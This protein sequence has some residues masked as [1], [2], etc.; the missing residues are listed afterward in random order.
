MEGRN[1]RGGVGAVGAHWG[2]DEDEGWPPERSKVRPYG[3]SRGAAS[4]RSAHLHRAN[5]AGLPNGPGGWSG[6]TH[7]VR[8]HRPLLHR[9]LHP[10]PILISRYRKIIY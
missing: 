9:N 5:T 1:R 8:V 7:N 10:A 6:C 2:E 3:P 4:V